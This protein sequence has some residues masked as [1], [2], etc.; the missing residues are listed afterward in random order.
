[1]LCQNIFLVLQP[2]MIIKGIINLTYVVIFL[3]NFTFNLLQI[4]FLTT[5]HFV[6]SLNFRIYHFP[7][8]SP[9]KYNFSFMFFNPFLLLSLNQISTKLLK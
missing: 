8:D 3:I 7:L 5:Q 4:L 1:M 6:D 9:V 2:R